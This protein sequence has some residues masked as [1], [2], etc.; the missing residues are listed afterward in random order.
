MVDSS[1][2]SLA[3]YL[4]IGGHWAL[5]IP[6][7]TL[8]LAIRR[9]VGNRAGEGV[10]LNNLG[11]LVGN[12]GRTDEAIAYL[13]QA[14]AITREVGVRRG[15]GVTLNSLGFLADN[16]GRKEAAARYYEQALAIFQEIGALDSERV[17]RGN[18]DAL[19][20]SQA[21]VTSAPKP[22]RRRIWPFG[23]RGET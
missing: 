6:L 7:L 19:R 2:D 4:Y 5:G 13:Q 20:A 16:L 11:N 17:V 14:L 8:Q 18:L 9:E 23:R 22:K 1:I 3:E 10:T 12:Q 21:T 15:E